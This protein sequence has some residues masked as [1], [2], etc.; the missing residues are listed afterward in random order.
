MQGDL[1][2][3]GTSYLTAYGIASAS[4][5]IEDRSLTYSVTVPVGS[6]GFVY[7]DSADVKEQGEPIRVGER[8]VLNVSHEGQKTTIKIGSGVYEFLAVLS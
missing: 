6:T 7:L 8:G 2:Q 3:A 5:F 1:H 4:W